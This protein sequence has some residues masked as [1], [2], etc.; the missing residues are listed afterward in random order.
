MSKEIYGEGEPGEKS[1]FGSSVALNNNGT[2]VVISSPST[3][4]IRSYI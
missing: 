2:T 3:G 4:V 1:D